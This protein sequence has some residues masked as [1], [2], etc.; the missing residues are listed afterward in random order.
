M[1][2]L[3]KDEPITKDVTDEI[4]REIFMHL[5]IRLEKNKSPEK[6]DQILKTIHQVLGN[7]LK[8]PLD[9]KFHKLK[10][11]NKKIIEFI[12]SNIECVNLLELLGF[13]Q[14]QDMISES[15]DL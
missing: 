7:I 9:T 11:Q 1:S 2:I 14:R 13:S 8:D 15:G 10:L 6:F 5:K 4:A 12:S 3:E